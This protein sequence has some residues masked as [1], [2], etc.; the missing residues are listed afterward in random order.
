MATATKQRKP[1]HA[2]TLARR[3]AELMLTKKGKDVVMLD[4]RKLTDM[5]DFF[6]IC[7]AD[8]DTQLKAIADAVHDGLAELGIKPYRTEGWSGGQWIIL[9]YVEV[10]VHVFYR[11]ARDFYKIERLWSDATV[12]RVTDQPAAPA[13]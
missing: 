5:A 11:E 9:D 7:S 8:S 10:V 2:K 3:C 6:V 4:I 1:A 12:E 13:S